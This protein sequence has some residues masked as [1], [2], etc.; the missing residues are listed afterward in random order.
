MWFV[1]GTSV[2]VP[3]LVVAACASL[4]A[5]AC[6]GSS[7]RT[8]APS[9]EPR[10]DPT[11]AVESGQRLRAVFIE[12]ADGLAAF[13]DFYD[14]ELDLVCR[15][16][17]A[18][19]D[20]WRCLPSATDGV[21]ISE[22]VYADTG[23]TTPL[24]PLYAPSDPVSRCA[25]PPRYA[26]LA[27]GCG[28]APQVFELGPAS[29]PATRYRIVDGTC[30]AS[31]SGTDYLTTPFEA[32]PVPL[33]RFQAGR[34]TTREE[35]G[36]VLPLELRSD[37]GALVMQGFRDAAEGFDCGLVDSGAEG[38]CVPTDQGFIGAAFADSGCTEPAAWAS[39]CEQTRA[40]LGFARTF[41]GPLSYRRGGPRLA[42]S[43]AGTPASC[44]ASTGVAFAVGEEIPIARFAAG[45]RVTVAGAELTITR[46]TVGSAS[47][48][49]R[50]LASTTHD[51][52]ACY[53]AH[54]TDGVLRCMPP[55]ERFLD[56]LFA[57]E[58]CRVP[59]E[60]TQAPFLATAA[61]DV[62]PSQIRV[63]ARGE[64]HTAPVYALTDGRCTQVYDRPPNDSARTPYYSFPREIP[65]SEFARLSRVVR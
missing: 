31:S 46:D 36:G 15:F 26:V 7:T 29:T 5:V 1:R 33:E 60:Y 49:A 12:S 44:T 21:A 47:L 6:G 35:T 63:L 18:A 4:S 42:A 25:P 62:C 20:R 51:G 9:A 23:C 55:P 2:S 58:A 22:I 40:E 41:S 8:P 65:A 57:D 64:R 38:R 37:D 19:A 39:T 3:A 14:V 11:G 17:E 13:A 32:T 54:G 50:S 30:V 27:P 59:V 48:P 24:A 34:L 61:V 56:N 10:V 43:Y 52:H 53:V 28:A 45:S 16:V